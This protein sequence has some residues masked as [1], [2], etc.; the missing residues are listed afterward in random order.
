M[1]YGYYNKSKKY[2]IPSVKYTVRHS[3]KAPG[4]TEGFKMINETDV[5]FV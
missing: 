5:L 2:P 1:K 4:G 3:A